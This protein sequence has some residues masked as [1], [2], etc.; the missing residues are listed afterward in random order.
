MVDIDHSISVAS[1]PEGCPSMV[2]IDYSISAVASLP[3][4]CPSIVGISPVS[5]YRRKLRRS[6]LIIFL[7]SGFN[8]LAMLSPAGPNGAR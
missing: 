8:N 6:S 4:G 7:K 5:K 1:L 3:E 2:D